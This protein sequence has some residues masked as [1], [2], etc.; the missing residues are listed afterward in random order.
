LK[1]LVSFAAYNLFFGAV[2]PVIDNTAHLGGFVSG[3]AL[4]ALLA[5]RLTSPPDE[6]NSWRRWV[7]ILAGAVFVAAFELARRVVLRKFAPYV[8]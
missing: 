2:V 6:R 5:P 7:F 3:L 8:G 1:S 4:G